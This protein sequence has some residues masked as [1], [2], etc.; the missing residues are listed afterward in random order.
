MDTI[1]KFLIALWEAEAYN[2]MY[3][4]RPIKTV[5]LT[6]ANLQW[7]ETNGGTKKPEPVAF[8]PGII[9]DVGSAVMHF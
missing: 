2:E 9:K 6:S 4:E 5:L 7:L 1:P 8:L 3:P